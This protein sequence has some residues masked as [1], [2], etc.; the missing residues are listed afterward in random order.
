MNEVNNIRN[1]T[2]LIKL[3][4]RLNKGEIKIRSNELMGKLEK[5]KNTYY[6]VRLGL[7]VGKLVSEVVY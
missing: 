6:T 4:E 7:D 5:D 1:D 3:Q 2:L